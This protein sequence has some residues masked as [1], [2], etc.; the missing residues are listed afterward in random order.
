MPDTTANIDSQNVTNAVLGQKLDSLK[1]DYQE[2]NSLLREHITQSQD[3][4][5]RIIILE[6]KMIDME[7]LKSALIGGS[8]ALIGFLI[9]ALVILLRVKMP[10]LP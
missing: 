2:L 4:E 10:M 6:T 3:R 8:L 7:R 5:K 1:C 9:T